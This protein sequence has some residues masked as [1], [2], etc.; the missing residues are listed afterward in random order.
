MST[1]AEWKRI[2][3]LFK[4]VRCR[5][6]PDDIDEACQAAYKAGLRAGRSDIAD[7]IDDAADGTAEHWICSSCATSLH[8]MAKDLRNK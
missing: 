3:K 2:S 5:N 7:A 4:S 6:N 1:F 8:N